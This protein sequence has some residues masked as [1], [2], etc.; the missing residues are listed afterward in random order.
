MSIFETSHIRNVGLIGHGD[1]GKTTLASSLL[2]QCGTLSR[3]GRVD[4]GTAVTD[5][6]PEEIDRKMSIATALAHAEWRNQR[7]NLIDTPGAAAFVHE[8]N[9][10]LKVADTA[11]SVVCGVSAVEVQT[12]RTWRFAREHGLAQALV[13]NKLDR[14]RADYD[15][16]LSALK[17]RFGRQVVAVHLPVGREASFTGLV[18]LL[19]MK[20]YTYPGDGSGK[21]TEQ[22]IPESLQEQAAAA[23]TQLVEM[24]AELDESLMERFFDKGTLTDEELISGLR[25]GIRDRKIFP[26]LA[27]SA[28]KGIGTDRLAEFIATALPD[29]A[30]RGT[31]EGK[32]PGS[33]EPVVREVT[34]SA[35]LSLFV[36]K[37]LADPFAGR[38]SLFRVMSGTARSEQQV[39]NYSRGHGEKLA[40]LS[41]MQGKDLEKVAELRVGDLGSVAKLK[42]TTTGNTLG[43]PANPILYEPV[44][45]PEGAIS[46]AIEPKTR[47]DEDKLS[48][49][50]ARIME[51]D[52]GL[53]SSRDPQTKEILLSGTG[54]QHVEV[55]LAKMKKK[56]GVDCLLNP[57]KVPYRET[58]KRKAE[59]TARHKKQTGGHG[60]FA[61]CKIVMEP[62]ERGSGYEFVDKIFGGAIS[63]G[64][65]PA[66]DK[67]IQ[68][69]AAR[70]F[71]AGY[72]MS[73]FRVTLVDGKEHQVDSSEMAF[74]IAASLAFKECMNQ[75][76]P[77]LLEP[78]MDVEVHTTEE[79]MGDIMGDMNSRR[80]RVQ[81]MENAGGRQVVRAQV[82]MA[83]MLTYA[84]TLKS[85]TGGRGTFH[86][87]LS[88]YE[89]VPA[90][91]QKKIAAEAERQRKGVG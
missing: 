8:A 82:P 81:G 50:M 22:D 51:E 63:Q 58:I 25:A 27:L 73:D 53:S 9:A 23:R 34:A 40:N 2:F 19:T 70:G 29:P 26:V 14:E 56:F 67:G 55:A 85:I 49:A 13:I 60:Q 83:E 75:A 43:D 65:R 10:A 37:T 71:V 84:Q 18:D 36:F 39:E 88:H 30:A 4:D 1:S 62:L 11:L 46:F 7:I 28:L 21:G 17:E 68:E 6:D 66:V 32:D 64:Y 20:A 42:D 61:E 5:F 79:F 31:V 54:V 47:G 72:P 12:E 89:E 57:P 16:V 3:L 24:V 76:S 41:I 90:M 45:P 80:G 86:M 48:S 35:P 15:R 91:I 38:I 87:S 33:Q 44:L 69:A 52:P 77:T 59:A 74:K 78:I